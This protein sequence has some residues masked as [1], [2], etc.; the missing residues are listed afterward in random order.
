MEAENVRATFH[1]TLLWV[2]EEFNHSWVCAYGRYASPAAAEK[3]TVHVMNSLFTGDRQYNRIRLF[4]YTCRT[5]R[6]FPYAAHIT[7]IGRRN[8]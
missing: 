1:T 8:L 6:F 3:K 5:A 2:Y 4:L 7:I